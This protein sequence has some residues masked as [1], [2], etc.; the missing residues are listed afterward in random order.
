MT[1]ASVSDRANR[2]SPSPGQTVVVER[3]I[4][5]TAG[6]DHARAVSVNKLPPLHCG[7]AGVLCSLFLI[8]STVF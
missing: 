3:Q 7:V 8:T 5:I 4:K 2:K 6:Y 1:T